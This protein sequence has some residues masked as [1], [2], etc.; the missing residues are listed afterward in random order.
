MGWGKGFAGLEW[1]ALRVE[2]G[3]VGVQ[4]DAVPCERFGGCVEG[5][6]GG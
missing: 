6:E 1:W 3:I 2:V 4:V 5:E